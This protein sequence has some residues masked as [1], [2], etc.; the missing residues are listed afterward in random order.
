MSVVFEKIFYMILLAS[1]GFALCKAGVADHRQAK[2]LSVLEVYLFLPANSIKTYSANFTVEYF[3]KN[4]YLILVSMAIMAVV[5][6]LAEL[7]ARKLTDD[8]YR[9][10][11]YRYSLIFS[12]YGLIGYAL[13][14][15]LFGELMLQDAMVFAFP[16]GLCAYT[17][18]YSL[19]SKTGLNLKKLI[20]PP[21]IAIFIGALFGLTGMQ[22]PSVIST[23]LEKASACMSP[24]SM[25]LTGMVVS[26]FDIRELLR[27]KSDYVVV[28]CRLLLVPCAIA[29]T[30]KLLGLN[31]VVI[32]ALMMYAMPCG[33]N[34]II[35]P[36]LIGENCESGAALALIS[37]LL[38]CVTIPVC[39]FLFA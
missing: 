3:R 34:T 31:D 38:A 7:V 15:D 35:V 5:I 32:P 23:T 29:G 2:L 13:T 27:R 30:L 16:M 19:L 39:V 9:R 4:Y 6:I 22:L 21:I 37:N 18:G 20:N 12:N 11:V 36:R 24:V 14:A 33:L 17:L 8:P 26:E 1:A 25:I 10:N 28:L